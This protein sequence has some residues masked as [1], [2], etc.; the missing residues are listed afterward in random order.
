[1]KDLPDT[2]SAETDRQEIT[3]RINT[4]DL[5]RAWEERAMRARSVTPVVSFGARTD[6]GRV[7]ENNEDKFEFFLPEDPETLANKGSLFAVADGMGGHSAGQVASEL[8]LKTV[9]ESY[10]ADPSPV[11]SDSLRAA[12]AKA[13]ALIYDTARAIVERSGMGTTLTGLVVRGEEAFIVHVGDSRCYLLRGG[14]LRQLTDDHSWVGEQLRLGAINEEEAASSPFRNIITRSLGTSP[15]VEADVLEESVQ[16]G[17]VFLLCTDGLSGDLSPDDIRA[18]LSDGG[19]SKV[20]WD[21]VNLALERGGRD[22]ITAMVVAV[23]EIVT[24]RSERRGLG[25]LFRRG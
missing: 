11:V 10:Y 6:L 5:R 21:L 15:A 24:G 12:V 13:N 2:G 1:M 25:S 17:D 4:E 16:A 7:R 14:T 9:V 3:A 20:A 22:N 23:R 8:A 19:A 18:A